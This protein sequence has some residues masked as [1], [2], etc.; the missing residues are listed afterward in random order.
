M[1]T[2]TLLIIEDNLGQQLVY[3]QL[4]E[5]FD[6]A[7][8]F[9]SSGEDAL[10]AVALARYAAVLVDFKLPGIN[11]AETVRRLRHLELLTGHRAP[12]IA[13][14]ASNRAEDEKSL[15]DSGVDDF[16]TKP[17]LI[18]DFRKLLLRQIYS[19]ERPNL[20]LLMLPKDSQRSVGD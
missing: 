9:C 3:R 1:N 4:C 7:A 16:M 19:S 13:L 20:K 8:V 5:M 6:C 14:T 15:R 2:A 18:D 17:F 12:I 10:E 11:G